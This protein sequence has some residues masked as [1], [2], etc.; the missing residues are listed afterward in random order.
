[1]TYDEYKKSHSHLTSSGPESFPIT[2]KRGN[3]L[4]AMIKIN[5]PTWTIEQIEKEFIRQMSNNM[6]ENSNGG[7]DACSG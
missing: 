2:D 6:D 4:K 5:N 3:F 1:M 7:C